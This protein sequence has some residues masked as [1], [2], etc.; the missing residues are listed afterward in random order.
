MGNPPSYPSSLNLSS[1]AAASAYK[2]DL[3]RCV[4]SANEWGPFAGGSFETVVFD[5]LSQNSTGAGTPLDTGT[6]VFTI[7]K[8]GYWVISSQCYLFTMNP[9]SLY[10]FTIDVN[11]AQV[12]KSM[13]TAD[14]TTH[15]FSAQIMANLA[16]NDLITITVKAAGSYN[17]TKIDG[18]SVY[19]W[20]DLIHYPQ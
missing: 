5:Q 13:A 4:I 10:Q 2:A 12:A 9:S 17:L 19:S 15:F 3:Y 6:G 11:G 7:P 14:T 8:A 18:N 20:F 16:A 1:E